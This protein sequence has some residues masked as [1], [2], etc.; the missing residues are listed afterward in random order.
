MFYCDN[1]KNLY[2]LA[3]TTP[4]SSDIGFM[5]CG[6]CGHTKKLENTTLMFQTRSIAKNNTD[7]PTEDLKHDLFQ[8]RIIKSCTNKRCP[9]A[10][11]P[12]E[13]VVYRDDDFNT[14]YICVSC[15]T[16]IELKVSSH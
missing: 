16:K 3:K 6:N 13:V 7:I 2:G 5:R 12:T 1:C 4:G 10:S 14:Y 11:G 9:S 8:H 15:S